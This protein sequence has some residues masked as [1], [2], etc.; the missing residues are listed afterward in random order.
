MAKRSQDLSRVE[1]ALLTHN[2]QSE[3]LLADSLLLRKLYL[4]VGVFAKPKSKLKCLKS[5][6]FTISLSLRSVNY[7]IFILIIRFG[8]TRRYSR[9]DIL[10][11]YNVTKVDRRISR[12]DCY[13]IPSSAAR[14]E[15][16][17][18]PTWLRLHCFPFPFL[19]FYLPY[20]SIF[21][22]AFSLPF[23][24]FCFFV[25]PWKITFWIFPCIYETCAAKRTQW[26]DTWP[27]QTR[28]R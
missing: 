25:F 9:C 11:L 17:F 18:L 10:I 7:S 24:C 8:K 20:F 26:E 15:L 27:G 28:P 5:F 16:L 19:S 21:P 4:S 22:E 6:G 12:C 3:T 13:L 2:T 23:H 14:M 1:K